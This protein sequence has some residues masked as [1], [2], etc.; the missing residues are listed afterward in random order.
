MIWS[1]FA[2]LTSHTP[3]IILLLTKADILS[4]DQQKEVVSF[5]QDTLQRG[6]SQG[7]ACLSYSNKSNTEEYKQLVEENIS[8]LFAQ[9]GIPNSQEF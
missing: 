7:I 5:F 8:R 1:L 9:T 4:P 3:N 6:T 2:K